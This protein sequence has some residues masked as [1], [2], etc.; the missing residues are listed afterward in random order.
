MIQ[1]DSVGYSRVNDKS[2]ADEGEYCFC[3]IS[4]SSKKCK[5]DEDDMPS[6]HRTC[7]ILSIKVSI[8]FEIRFIQ[9]IN[10]TSLID[11]N[12]TIIID[13]QEINL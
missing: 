11:V 3:I 4:V 13:F 12:Q 8:V 9:T 5:Q 2:Q 6:A 1:V 10:L 7:M